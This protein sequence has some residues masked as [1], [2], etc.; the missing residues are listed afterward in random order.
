M[1]VEVFHGAGIDIHKDTAVVTIRHQSPDQLTPIRQETRTFRTLTVDLHAL[2]A[3]LIDEGITHVCLESTGSY[4]KPVYNLLEDTVVVWLINPSHV[5]PLRGRKTD[6]KDSQWL[7]E[8]LAFG[9]VV[10][11]FIPDKPQR[12]LREAVR[13]RRSL[14]DERAREVNRIQKVLEGGN[15]KLGS[16]ISD[17]LGVSGRAML[18]ALAVGHADPDQ[19]AALA[20]PRI[21]A[22][23][24]LLAQALTGVVGDH[25]R[26]ML[27]Q[28]LRHLADLE[29]LITAADHEIA[30]RTRPFDE[31]RNLLES[32]P[33]IQGRVADVI[34]AEIGP[35][36]EPFRSPAALAK[37]AGV[38]PGN[39]TS[40]GKRL[41]GRTTPGNKAL[42]SALVEAARGAGRTKSTYLGAQYK[43]L[44]PRLGP[45]RAALAVAHSICQRVWIV[46]DRRE[47][48]ADLGV[49]YF[50]RRDT[51]G[52]KRRA[53]KRLH[54]LGYHVTLEPIP[55]SP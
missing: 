6:V 36:V 8:L 7:A 17:V 10:P 26:W 31:A 52:V 51:E 28:Q 27:T 38:A 25:Q 2:R 32:I 43:R 54:D 40:G 4:W 23:A 53:V 22:S 33:G 48:Y 29:T 24:A 18:T 12:E 30:R 55:Q 3:W 5:K 42:R 1:Q 34:L 35:S 44:L 21:R 15:I 45:K 37:W 20:D 39:K 41:S 11:S 50:D 49:D 14:I 47:P 13:Y 19:L 9:L 46:L 16:V